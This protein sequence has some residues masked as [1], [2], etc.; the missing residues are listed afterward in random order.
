MALKENDLKWFR[1]LWR[2]VA[3]AVFLALWLGWE[4]LYTQD[5]FWAFLVGAALAYVAWNF[6]YTFPK[7]T[8]DA[9]LP[10]AD[11]SDEPD[12]KDP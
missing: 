8:A 6:F 1:P 2:R 10:P 9:A 7:E 12:R 4:L 5:M 11:P 3:V